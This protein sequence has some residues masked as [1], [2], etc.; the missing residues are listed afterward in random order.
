MAGGNFG[1]NSGGS[2]KKE[3]SCENL[4]ISTNITTPEEQLFGTISV[5]DSLDVKLT[6][7]EKSVGVFDSDGIS[8]GSIIDPSVIQLINCLK[9]GKKFIAQVTEVDEAYIEINIFHHTENSQ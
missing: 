9:D 6:N 4:I 1:P 5:N 2:G 7:N 3:K 8:V